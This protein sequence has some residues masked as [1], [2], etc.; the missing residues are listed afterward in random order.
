MLI[1]IA[2]VLAVASVPLL[3]GR[4]GRLGSLRLARTWTLF[5]ALA[6]QILTFSGWIELNEISASLHL[7][8]YMLAGYFVFSNRH[9]SGLWLV[10]LGGIL[11]FTAILSN[12]GVMP[13]SPS[14]LQ[15]AGLSAGT[16][17][18]NS[19]AVAQPSLGFLGDIYGLPSSWPWAN[20][21][22]I[23]DVMLVIGAFFVLHQLT[24]SRLSFSKRS[25]FQELKN[26][27]S[28]LVVLAAQAISNTGDWVYALAVA[29]SV[30]R[31]GNTAHVFSLLLVAQVGPAAL[32]GLFGGP[33][34]DRFSRKRFMIATDV[35]RALAVG[36]LLVGG[37][38]SLPHLYAVA[39]VLGVM[40]A[41]FQPS[42]Q[43]CLPNLVPREQLVAANAL[44]A[45]TMNFAVMAGPIIAGVLVGKL[46]L[47]PALAINAGSFAFSAVL[48]GF[49]RN[50][51]EAVQPD[52]TQD[53]AYGGGLFDGLRYVAKT[54]LTRW[55]MIVTAIVMFAAAVKA[56]LEPLFV[57]RELHG[58]PGML[59]LVGGVWGIG[60]VAGSLS[61]PLVARRF[62]RERSLGAGI[63]AVG[64]SLLVV[65]TFSALGP[66]LIMW[67]IAGMGNALGNVAY[68]SLLQEQTPD[69]LR[70]RV[71]AATEAVLDVSYLLGALAAGWAGSRF[72]ISD[73]Y[74]AIG[75][76]FVLAAAISHFT[77]GRSR[78]RIAV[79]VALPE[80]PQMR[81]SFELFEGCRLVKWTPEGFG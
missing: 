22:S 56:P 9:I 65:S 80:A 40:G 54:P 8:S 16:G 57:L 27:P 42:L 11:N 63:L 5:V 10:A 47:G 12:G 76:L 23:G 49:M 37:A 4:L 68:E 79:P 38:P 46:G 66:L 36:S 19:R 75:L 77:L 74:G 62:R 58:S 45:A 21:F 48:I 41:L 28:F 64:C 52:E 67:M 34:I 51:P 1:L 69:R 81:E 73:V 71:F 6:V 55:I 24:G 30:A 33:L 18:V 17:F 7:A 39:A 14:A 60:M 31:S 50:R 2:V 26:S 59:G 61:A 72:A 43:A 70:G 44:V 3:G 25:G 15:N 32:T 13:A 20:V 35:S 53:D 29:V 78:S